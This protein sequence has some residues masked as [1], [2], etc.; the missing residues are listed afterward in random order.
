MIGFDEINSLKGAEDFLSESELEYIERYFDVMEL[1]EEEKE[2]R[3]SFAK[4]FWT[5]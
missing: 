3:K 1:T 4:V 2:N 5:L